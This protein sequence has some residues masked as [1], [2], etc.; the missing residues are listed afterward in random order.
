MDIS[1]DELL[2]KDSDI[3]LD[4]GTNKL[5]DQDPD[6][7]NPYLPLNKF[8]FG[9]DDYF[10]PP[11][12][13]DS[14]E[15]YF[16]TSPRGYDQIASR[17]YGQGANGFEQPASEPQY[18][19]R[20]PPIVFDR[21]RS[22]TFERSVS[23]TGSGVFSRPTSGAFS[24]I[25]SGTLGLADSG[26]GSPYLSASHVPERP[27]SGLLDQ[28]AS[29][30]PEP[31]ARRASFDSVQTPGTITPM[32]IFDS[33]APMRSDTIP[34]AL[35][36]TS[37]PV[38]R[39]SASRTPHPFPPFQPGE[40]N[41]SGGKKH[42]CTVCNR[43]F[44]RPSTLATHLNSHTGEQPHLCPVKSCG[45]RFSVSSNLKRHVKRHNLSGLGPVPRA[46]RKKTT[47][48]RKGSEKR[49]PRVLQE[50]KNVQP[51]CPES[52]R[53]MR[54]AKSLS[55]RPPFE[56]LERTAPLRAPLPAVRPHG[57]LGD[58]NYEDRD[59]FFYARETDQPCSAS[60]TARRREL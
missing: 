18:H 29:H 23:R 25:S 12:S 20:P 46:Q 52:L 37:F 1:E 42:W 48:A 10:I 22:L 8:Q 31:F 2:D 58:E 59:S 34:P 32:R 54:N 41:R 47:A 27:C 14:R 17:G 5:L 50:R 6:E 57:Q 15:P 51:W 24:H 19:S 40:M 11:V 7:F 33:P 49:R 28:P 16:Q 45:S 39:R 21:R 44:T 13:Y 38:D 30:A 53:G 9:S 36:T 56:M 3:Q 55:S 35:S 4:E 26:S 60:W 43:G